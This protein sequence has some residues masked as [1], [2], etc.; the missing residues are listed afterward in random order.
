MFKRNWFLVLF[1]A[2]F[3]SIA[4]ACGNEE[5]SSSSDSNGSGNEDDNSSYPSD[6]VELVVPASAGGDTDRNARLLAQ[7]LEEELD[8]NVVVQNVTGSSGSVG[9][10]ELMNSEPDGHRVLYFHNNILINNLL[11]VSEN[12]YEDLKIVGISELD[13][14]NGLVVSSDSEYDNLDD[15]IEDAKNNPGQID[16]RTTTGSFTHIQMLNFEQEAGIDFNFVDAGDFA[17]RNSSLL[18]GHIDVVPI[19]LGLAN[20]YIESGDMKS[21]GVLSENRLDMY[22]EVPTF[23]EEGVDISFEKF[24]FTAVPQETPDEVVDVLSE[25]ISNVV[26]NE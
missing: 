20:E 16:L 25:A 4:A 3:V 8:T 11:G 10:Q 22:P 12:T 14:S 19:Q 15:L 24:F 17:E 21:L 13:N 1:L 5:A 9:V 6:V 26:N 7:Y 18:G 2:L 23:M